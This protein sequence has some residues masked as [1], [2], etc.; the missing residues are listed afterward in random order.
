MIFMDKN[1]RVL[2][3]KTKNVEKSN[4]FYAMADSLDL[5]YYYLRTNSNEDDEGFTLD[6]EQLENE[7]SIVFKQS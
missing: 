7:L 1:S 4:A 2:E 6:L 3:V 5:K